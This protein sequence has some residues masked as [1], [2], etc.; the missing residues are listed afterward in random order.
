MKKI[1]FISAIVLLSNLLSINSNAA[2]PI[3]VVCVGNSITEGSGL[4]NAASEAYPVLLKNL[5]GSNYEV[6]NAGVGGKTMFKRASA[7]TYWAVPQ[8]ALAKEYNPDIVFIALGTNDSKPQNWT[9]YKSEFYSDY[10]SMISE[11]RQNGRDPHI[12]VCIPPPAFIDNFGITDSV[13]RGRIQ[14]LID[15][16]CTN[17]KTSKLDL[18]HKMLPYG[19]YFSDGIHPDKNGHL[20]IAKLFYDAMTKPIAITAVNNPISKYNQTNNE[21]ITVSI[22]NNNDTTLRNI[23]VIYQI[24]GGEKVREVIDSLPRHREVKYTFTKKS[25]FSQLREYAISVY[26]EMTNG[27]ANDTIRVKTLNA[28]K[29]T[30][31]AIL[32]SGDNGRI[33]IPHALGQTSALAMTIEAWI[34]PTAFKKNIYDGTVISKEESLKGYSLT[35]GATGQAAFSVYEKT[36]KQA[37]APVGTLVLNKWQHLAGVYDGTSIKLYV[38][39]KLVATTTTGTMN[40]STNILCFGQTSNG[41]ADRSFIGGIDEIRIWGK[42]LT[43]QEIQA[44]NAYQLYG[45]E[46]GLTAYYKM[47][48]GFGATNSADSTAARRFG[49]MINLDVK[50]CWIP[51]AGLAPKQTIN[52]IKD[53]KSNMGIL[54]CSNPVR[55]FVTVKLNRN[56]EDVRLIVTDMVGRV[57][58]GRVYQSAGQD[59]KVN[60]QGFAK[61]VYL[62]TFQRGDR[63]ETVKITVE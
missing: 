52:K 13:I 34:Y 10:A 48:D 31:L 25:D 30:D 3:R 45:T 39:G 53:L 36:Q 63:R 47:N 42:A 24:D 4:S 33:K 50:H 40:V 8:Y 51:G 57:A 23:P 28:D 17:L 41:S 11:F 29:K 49:Y 61:G 22:N 60:M 6:M 59:I 7:A 26:T 35:V 21:S 19:N 16:L 38:D 20:I 15:S 54:I 44:Q 55:D 37:I 27:Q 5:L 58:M 12:F 32:F 62:F 14:P 1:K 2:T 46:T 9:L 56:D 18:F 43:Q